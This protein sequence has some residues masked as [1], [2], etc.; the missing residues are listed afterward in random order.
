MGTNYEHT[1]RMTNTL[2]GAPEESQSDK[3]I[4]ISKTVHMNLEFLHLSPETRTSLS[5]VKVRNSL[6]FSTKI[7]D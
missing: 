1:V 5:H 7:D 3:K 4:Y 6:E 2:N